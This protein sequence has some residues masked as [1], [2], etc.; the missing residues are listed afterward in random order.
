MNNFSMASTSADLRQHSVIHYKNI[1]GAVSNAQYVMYQRSFGLGRNVHSYSFSM[2]SGTLLKMSHSSHFI[3]YYK[4][5]YC[6]TYFS[7]MYNT[8]RIYFNACFCFLTLQQDHSA[9]HLLELADNPTPLLVSWP[10]IM[11]DRT[12][13][14]AKNIWSCVPVVLQYL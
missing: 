11:K 12:S 8:L 4:S 14:L 13:S 3:L 1:F 10:F 5:L 9:S 6:F 2:L 7:G